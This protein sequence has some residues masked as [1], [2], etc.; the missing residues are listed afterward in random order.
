M[1]G[2]LIVSTEPSA[3]ASMASP[4]AE[5]LAEVLLTEIVRT[6]TT[7]G[8]PGTVLGG[9]PHL[10]LFGEAIDLALP[11]RALRRL[12][13][14][15]PLP[16]LEVDDATLH[17]HGRAIADEGGYLLS[18]AGLRAELD[19]RG[20][21]ADTMSLWLHSSPFSRPMNALLRADPSRPETWL[22]VTEGLRH[23][24]QRVMADPDRMGCHALAR[25]MSRLREAV[26]GLER[27]DDPRLPR[28]LGEQLVHAFMALRAL[29]RLRRVLGDDEARLRLWCTL[30][31]AVLADLR[32]T[33]ASE[34]GRVWRDPGLLS[35]VVDRGHRAHD[36]DEPD[37]LE[38]CPRVRGSA[39]RWLDGPADGASVVLFPPGTPFEVV[40]VI[41]VPSAQSERHRVVARLQELPARRAIEAWT[42]R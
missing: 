35:T 9:R 14:R 40:K 39:G 29:P 13:E 34:G 10:R 22:R 12:T 28:L 27:L 16:P 17:A 2:K 8:T 33:A 20:A 15:A 19:Q 26:A 3:G 41:E 36:P 31:N 4:P 1:N 24:V 6:L 42:A 37:V 18:P 5:Q 25:R 32:W 23:A 21:P 38:L 11:L 7:Q 30:P